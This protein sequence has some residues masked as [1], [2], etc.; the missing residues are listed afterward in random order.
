M[1]RL[2][3]NIND[4][5]GSANRGDEYETHKFDIQYMLKCY[6]DEE[7]VVWDPFVAPSGYSQ[8]FIKSIGYKTVVA[9]RDFFDC[10]QPPA[11]TTLIVTNPPFSKKV[12]VMQKLCDWNVP[13]VVVMPTIVLQRDYFTNIVNNTK[14]RWWVQL[15][16]KSLFFHSNGVKQNLPAFKC[17]FIS[18]TPSTRYGKFED[19][20]IQP[21]DYAAIRKR[22]GFVSKDVAFVH[23]DEEDDE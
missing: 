11:G 19:I 20:T 2:P 22:D 21:I 9:D 10:E 14:R 8:Q 15:P 17:C 6:S 7:D 18:S 4:G 1:N 13:F 16:N 3:V 12:Q 23:R 5:D